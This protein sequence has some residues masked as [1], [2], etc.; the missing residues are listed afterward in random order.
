MSRITHFH[1]AYP[2]FMMLILINSFTENAK[3]VLK[4]L[5]ASAGNKAESL[6]QLKEAKNFLESLTMEVMKRLLKRDPTK[7][8][9]PY[10]DEHR[11]LLHLSHTLCTLNQF[12]KKGTVSLLKL[13]LN[14]WFARCL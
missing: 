12:T 9:M 10:N 1:G 4:D 7:M 2:R 11:R 8:V 3:A 5:D 14:N 13:G 6:E